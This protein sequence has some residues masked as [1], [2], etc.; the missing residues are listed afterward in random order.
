MWDGTRI[1]VLQRIVTDQRRFR[2]LFYKPFE[3]RKQGKW[4]K[5]S[6]NV[7]V[8]KAYGFMENNND[9]IERVCVSG[10]EF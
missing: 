6:G 2:D 9:I 10:M 8:A 3:Y 1:K 5:M 4:W 7:H